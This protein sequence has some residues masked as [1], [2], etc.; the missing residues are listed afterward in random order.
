[1][2]ICI[3]LDMVYAA[4]PQSCN[5]RYS[6]NSPAFVLSIVHFRP[7]LNFLTHAYTRQFEDSLL[8][9]QVSST[10]AH[11]TWTLPTVEVVNLA[12]AETTSF[13]RAN[14]SS[15]RGP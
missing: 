1:M 9:I 7:K 3:L 15:F 6:P 12:A 10:D 2:E 4:L 11:G 5:L 8:I 14:S 13:H